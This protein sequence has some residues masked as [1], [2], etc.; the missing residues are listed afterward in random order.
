MKSAKRAIMEIYYVNKDNLN[1]WRRFTLANTGKWKLDDIKQKL[2]EEYNWKMIPFNSS[3]NLSIG[4]LKIDNFINSKNK[5]AYSIFSAA[6]ICVRHL[7]LFI[8]TQIL[9]DWLFYPSF[10]LMYEIG[11]PL[12]FLMGRIG[13]PQGVPAGPRSPPE[14]GAPGTWREEQDYSWIFQPLRNLAVSALPW[15]MI[16]LCPRSIPP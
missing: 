6:A 16:S 11:F 10:L 15:S 4:N 7:S 1:R 12:L 2:H 8:A 13:P 3:W 9:R 5:R 14:P